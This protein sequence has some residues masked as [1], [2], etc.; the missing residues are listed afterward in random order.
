MTMITPS[1]LGETIEYSS[2]HACRST[3]E[4]PTRKQPRNT[5]PRR[6]HQS[7]HR[8][9]T[10]EGRASVPGPEAA[11]RLHEDTLP[12]TCQKPGTALHAVRARQPLPGSTAAT[13]MRTSLS[14]AACAAA[15]STLKL[16]IR[17]NVEEVR[18]SETL[19][20]ANRRSRTR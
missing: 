16:P 11:V 6:A 1:Y 3:L 10:G 14:N 4:D 17:G 12:G 19:R 18:C 8:D 5:S 9:G 15:K 13:G 20:P 2:L 7:D